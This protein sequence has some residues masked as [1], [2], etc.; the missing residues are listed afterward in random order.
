[1]SKRYLLIKLVAEQPTRRLS[2]E[3]TLLDSVRKSFGDFGVARINPRLIRFD[4]AKSLAVV[5]CSR[6]GVRD[7][8]VAIAMITGTSD[9]AMTALTLHVSGTIKGLSKKQRF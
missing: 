8:Q 2:F 5:A 1:M 7:L 6:E 9:S 4:T 3:T